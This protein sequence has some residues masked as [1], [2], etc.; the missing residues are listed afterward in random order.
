MEENTLKY[1]GLC[2]AVFYYGLLPP[3]IRGIA[4]QLFARFLLLCCFSSQ[5]PTCIEEI[6][7][8]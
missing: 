3:P 7:D 4:A 2:E 6:I 5:R 1:F 8:L